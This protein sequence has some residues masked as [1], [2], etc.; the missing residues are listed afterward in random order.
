MSKIPER[1]P[2]SSAE[3]DE[4]DAQSVLEVLRS[5]RLALGP[6]AEEFERLVA[7][8]VGCKHAVAVNSG[9]AALH[10]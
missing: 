2:M 8:Y 1:I 3:L 10:L 4:S 9:T 7:D 6:K 5:G